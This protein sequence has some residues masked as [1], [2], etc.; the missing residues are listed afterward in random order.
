MDLLEQWINETNESILGCK[1]R[2]KIPVETQHSKV[3]S[4][5]KISPDINQVLP[6]ETPPLG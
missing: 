2:H 3:M 4:L 5:N 1:E 6:H